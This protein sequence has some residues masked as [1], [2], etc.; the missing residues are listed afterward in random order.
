MVKTGLNRFIIIS[1]IYWSPKTDGSENSKI[2]MNVAN[3][4]FHTLWKLKP[5]N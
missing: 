1:E 5:T 4:I 3:I 2:F